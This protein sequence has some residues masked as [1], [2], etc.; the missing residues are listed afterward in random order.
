MG[1]LYKAVSQYTLDLD[2]KGTM[3]RD[4]I[5]SIAQKGT[6]P[7]TA[8]SLLKTYGSFQAGICLF[9][10]DGV[11]SGYA[12]VGLGIEKTL[13]PLERFPPGLS[14]MVPPGSSANPGP[15]RRYYKID[16]PTLLSMSSLASSVILWAFPLDDGLP[17]LSILLLAEADPSPFNPGIMAR[18]VFDIRAALLA[19][20]GTGSIVSAIKASPPK[21]APLSAPITPFPKERAPG[22]RVAT[23]TAIK[24]KAA[25]AQDVKDLL[26]HYYTGRPVQGILLAVSAASP[27]D[28][29]QALPTVVSFGSV[30][31]V[32]STYLL[33]LFQKPLDR[34][35]LAHRLSNSLG[36]T[37]V[38]TFEADTL[39]RLFGLLGPYSVE[40]Y[41]PCLTFPV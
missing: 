23:K 13:I 38:V 10:H 7:Y 30:I 32:S 1:L 34:E 28:A 27:K 14:G 3:L 36:L 35:L 15:R 9:L 37:T 20:K 4:R 2:D 26:I 39:E 33:V 25:L 11:Y 29:A 12:S 18:I 17:C 19:P 5:L 24:K 8:L 31:R 41:E 16:S 22:D 40:T 6:S 21:S